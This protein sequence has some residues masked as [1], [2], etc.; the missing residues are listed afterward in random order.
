MKKSLLS[1]ALGIAGVL[2]SVTAASAQVAGS[3]T[4]IGVSIT[5]TQRV[6]LGWSVRK[7]IL[8]KTVYNEAGVKVG[9]VQDLIVDPER[10]VS[11]VII[12]AG[13]F[14][15]LG[16]HDVAIPIAQIRD[17]GGKI[18]MQG[19]TKE[20]LRS[21][22]HFHYAYDTAR[23]DQFIADAD[24]GISAARKE[25]AVLDQKAATAAGDAKTK[26]DQQTAN[27]RRDLREAEDKLAGLTRARAERWK[28]FE[29]DVD[30][31]LKR[32]KKS[33][34]IATG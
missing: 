24:Q 18:V 13:G 5:E 9:R 7:S 14:V 1:V 30:A 4:T 6:A 21:L 28:D 26:L 12:N 34:G 3:S 20:T 22:P 23:R 16:Q 31:A 11:Y 27:L 10:N 29:D 32:L 19:A 15:G 25:I 17:Q 2:A 33:V 8:G